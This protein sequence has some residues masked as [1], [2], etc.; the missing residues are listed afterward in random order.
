VRLERFSIQKYRS[1]IKA[2]KLPLG[3]L[4]VLV[5]PN[6]EGKSNILQ[7]LVVGME[8]LASPRVRRRGVAGRRNREHGGY[9][10][11]RD[12]PQSLQAAEPN[13]HSIMDFDFALTDD[14]IDDFYGEVGSRL[15]GILP[16]R[17]SFGGTRASFTVRKQ[18]HAT[19]LSAKR[20][21]IAGF[22]AAR[23]QVQ[24]VPAVRTAERA[25]RIVQTMVR[26]ELR[27][28]ERD[29][30]YADAMRRLREL[31]EPVLRRIS[32]AITDKVQ[33][34][35]PDVRSITLEVDEDDRAPWGVGGRHRVIVDDGNP[36]ELDLKGDG[37]Q[38]LTAL[39]LIQHYSTASA[40]AK[41]FILAIEEPEA[42]LHPKAIH[43]LREVIR[44]TSSRQQVVVTT[45]SPL[46]VNRLET[47]RNIIVERTQARPASSVQE[48][49]S[50]L[51]VRTPDNLEGAEVVL[52]VE[53]QEDET[54]LRPLLAERSEALGRALADGM[55][56]LYPLHGGGNLNYALT[57]L[58]DSLAA[59][60]AFLD[61][62]EAGHQA[63]AAAAAEGLLDEPDRTFAI[64]S[65]K[66]ESEF[67][68]LVDPALYA[69]AVEDR[70]GVDVEVN[71]GRRGRSAGKWSSRM[72]L[73]FEA[74][75]E[76]WEGRKEGQLKALVAECV[77]RSPADAIDA[78]C[79][80]VVASLV[81]ALER[82]LAARLT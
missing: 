27:A 38:S 57:Q 5:G 70:F 30:E 43:A 42:H 50:V 11:D 61:S 41:E 72:P 29:T 62:D 75:G 16:L 44:E 52:V 82:K 12:F 21:E 20:D 26:R 24:Y 65:G 14:E 3:D 7:A 4:T 32:D 76:R 18:R 13:G 48:L 23:V 19:A 63:A 34:V 68:D 54:A 59:I 60:H 9:F 53:G 74:C 10:W 22:V 80:S 39:S 45:H 67:E 35:L 46:F 40:D 78:D 69:D 51:G 73:V 66:T 33:G 28:A 77:A 6:N 17:L 1:I 49:R 15:N 37:M 31:Q 81:T 56:T 2:E 55:L 25:S 47:S 36:T 71:L 8:E 79:D 64:R 58:R